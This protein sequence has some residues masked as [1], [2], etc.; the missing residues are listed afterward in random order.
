MNQSIDRC[1]R[2]L[3]VVHLLC[4]VQRRLIALLM[5]FAFSLLHVL[6]N[7]ESV[8]TGMM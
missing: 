1:E 5:L 7:L 3:S 8:T 2:V 6:L 4:S